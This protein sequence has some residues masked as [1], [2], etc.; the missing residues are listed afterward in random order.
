MEIQ[1]LIG[2]GTNT[3]NAK[4]TLR[5]QFQ[6]EKDQHV[7]LL[8]ERKNLAIA[9]LQTHKLAGAS[10][11][12]TQEI[13]RFIQRLQEECHSLEMKSKR[14]RTEIKER[15]DALVLDAQKVRSSIASCDEN[16]R[17][18]AFQVTVCEGKITEFK[19]DQVGISA[20]R[21]ELEDVISSISSEQAGFERLSGP[22]NYSISQSE[23]NVNGLV[24]SLQE[25]EGRC[26]T[27]RDLM[28]TLNLQADTRARLLLKKTELSRKTELSTRSIAMIRP[29]LNATLSPRQ[30]KIDSVQ[31]ELKNI[32]RA[33]TDVFKVARETHL[34]RTSQISVTESQIMQVRNEL[35]KKTKE[36]DGIGL[37]LFIDGQTRIRE[38]IGNLDY[39]TALQQSELTADTDRDA[40][41]SMKSASQMYKKFIMKFK[42]AHECPLCARGFTESN[43]ARAFLTRLEAVLEAAPVRQKEAMDDLARKEGYRRKLRGLSSTWDAVTRLQNVDLPQLR[44]QRDILEKEKQANQISL[45]DSDA[46]VAMLDVEMSH[47]NT[48]CLKTDD[49]LRVLQEMK[50]LDRDVTQLQ[51]DLSSTGSNQ[52]IDEVSALYE[53]TQSEW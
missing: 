36:L 50:V 3:L 1:A 31:D 30:F 46:E 5:G 19:R 18:T 28:S 44:A 40:S 6:A 15:E 51:Q 45:D 39:E 4:L 29:E 49:Y 23:E 12:T 24:N 14:S 10:C 38:V 48:L 27:Y 17:I 20:T 52:T 43:E 35:K 11:E 33:K 37:V 32:L 8:T 9:L 42:E 41:Y 21:D 26:Q 2:R 7:R 47:L 13:T 16:K 22:S 53:Q 25:K 34:K